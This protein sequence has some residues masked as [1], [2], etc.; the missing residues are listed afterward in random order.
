MKTIQVNLNWFYRLSVIIIYNL[1]MVLLAGKMVQICGHLEA[2]RS[3]GMQIQ[4]LLKPEETTFFNYS[5]SK[6]ADKGN[7][8]AICLPKGTQMEMTW[9]LS[10]IAFQN[11]NSI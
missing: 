7:L 2:L 10:V 11:M 4:S 3:P 6:I 1:I 8:F 9:R 5:E